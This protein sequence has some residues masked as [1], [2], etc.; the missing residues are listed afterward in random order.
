MRK[1]NYRR[2]ED[3]AMGLKGD[4]AVLC[5]LTGCKNFVG[6]RKKFIVNVF[7]NLRPMESFDIGSDM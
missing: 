6:K 7:L 1:R 4:H 3:T 5:R 2:A